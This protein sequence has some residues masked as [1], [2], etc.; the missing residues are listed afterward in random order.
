MSA[1]SKQEQATEVQ[2]AAQGGGSIT[3]FC[4]CSFFIACFTD[5]I[6]IINGRFYGIE[7]K[8][9]RDRQSAN[10]KEVEREII[11]AG[12]VYFIA[13]S[14]DDYL[15]KIAKTWLLTLTSLVH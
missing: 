3:W 15:E 13:K 1:A 6:G 5:I 10:Q 12:G 8:I 9:G 11:E 7:V 14:Y 2:V 4:R